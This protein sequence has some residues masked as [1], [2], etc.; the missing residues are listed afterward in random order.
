MIG[1]GR[2]R[3]PIH[4]ASGH[5]ASL[6]RRARGVRW[7]AGRE[8]HLLHDLHAL[9]QSPGDPGL[10]VTYLGRATPLVMLDLPLGDQ[11]PVRR[12]ASGC[13]LEACGWGT[14]L[15]GIVSRE[16][17][18]AAGMT[19]YD[20]DVIRVLETALPARFGGGPTDYQLVE[21]ETEFGRPADPPARAPGR[22][23]G[24][25]V[26]RGRGLPVGRGGWP[27]R[28]ADHGCCIARRAP[29]AHRAARAAHGRVGQGPPRP[30]LADSRCRVPGRDLGT[31]GPGS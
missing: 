5:P 26:D 28:R 6:V 20:T 8:R 10:F 21:E 19:F 3:R 27:Q 22:G 18:T 16:K 25:S 13:P 12:R 30:R 29:S 23:L 24:G 15:H 31:D 1:G 4:R 11:A 17:F 2:D 9:M 7:S 14:Y